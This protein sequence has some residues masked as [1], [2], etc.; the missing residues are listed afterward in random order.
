MIKV[1]GPD[2]I[3]T[4][5]KK[6]KDIICFLD[7]DGV[8]AYWLKAAANTLG[9]DLRSSEVRQQIKDG[10]R[11]E[12]FVGG[13]DVMWPKIDAEG[14]AWWENIE[15]LPWADDLI[16]LLKKETKDLSF[17]SSPSD[18]PLC[19]SGKIKWVLKNYPK[20]AR[21]VFLGCKKYRCASPNS[22]LIDDTLKKCKQFEKSGGQSFLWP[23]TIAILDGDVDLDET[24]KDLEA[25][26]NSMRT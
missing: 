15:K 12:D 21:D 10:K 14:D 5:K 4:A 8:C 20:M 2:K 6:K 3:I 26:I 9:V 18:S 24:M 16:N 23:Q 25:K 17:L 22:I 1:Q 19:Y 11:M 7:V 13:D